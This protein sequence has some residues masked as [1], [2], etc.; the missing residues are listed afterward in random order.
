MKLPN[1]V[2]IALIAA[3]I[4]FLQYIATDAGVLF[5]APWVPVAVLLIG[6]LVKALQVYLEQRPTGNEIRTADE[7][8]A[9]GLL[10]RT[11]LD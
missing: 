5:P 3:L 8:K 4:A 11:L 1:V 2:S 9:N 7:R 10:R 6:A